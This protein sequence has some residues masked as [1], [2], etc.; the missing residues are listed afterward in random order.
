MTLQVAAGPAGRRAGT[1]DQGE[2]SDAVDG[3]A[4]RGDLGEPLATQVV[5]QRPAQCVERLVVIQD[6]LTFPH[7]GRHAPR[8]GPGGPLAPSACCLL[9]LIQAALQRSKI[10][11][12]L[13]ARAPQVLHRTLTPLQL[14]EA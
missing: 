4:Q 6:A 9:C 14:P 5:L 1:Q 8:L 11:A 7:V 12:S 13:G 3:P 2:R 10:P